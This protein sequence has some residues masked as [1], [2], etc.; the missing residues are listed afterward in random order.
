MAKNLKRKAKRAQARADGTLITAS[1]LLRR[2]APAPILTFAL[3]TFTTMVEHKLVK[4][5]EDGKLARFDSVPQVLIR[6][7]TEKVKRVGKKTFTETHYSKWRVFQNASPVSDQYR[8]K[9]L[10]FIMISAPIT[11]WVAAGL[12]DG[13]V[14]RDIPREEQQRSFADRRLGSA[15][16]NVAANQNYK[17]AA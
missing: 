3:S 5:E 8:I 9:Q 15:L 4:I 6:E 7:L 17:K 16:K 12:L 14:M 1:K 2:P 11:A 10:P 13:M